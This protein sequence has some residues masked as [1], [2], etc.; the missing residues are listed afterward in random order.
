MKTSMA[1]KENT[2][3][4]AFNARIFSIVERF[5]GREKTKMPE[6]NQAAS[7]FKAT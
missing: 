2:S 4:I 6:L 1:N 7:R 5:V 3:W